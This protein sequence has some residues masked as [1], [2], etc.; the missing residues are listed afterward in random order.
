MN[1]N[2]TELTKVLDD[3]QRDSEY[4]LINVVI[5]DLLYEEFETVEEVSEFLESIFI[6]GTDTGVVP[7][8]VYRSN[9]RSLFFEYGE[10]IVNIAIDREI[11]LSDFRNFDE[12]VDTVVRV[13]Y[14]SEAYTLLEFIKHELP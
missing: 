4:E 9:I 6:Y 7:R 10:D 5:E 8:L 12:F 3:L 2:M 14:E 11:K 1:M 13:A